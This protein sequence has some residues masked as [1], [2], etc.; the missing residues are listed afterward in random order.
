MS[1]FRKTG[2][3]FSQAKSFRSRYLAASGSDEMRLKSQC[4]YTG[5]EN[6]GQDEEV[7]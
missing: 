7:A 2:Y 5:K 1:G 6:G 3:L 4:L